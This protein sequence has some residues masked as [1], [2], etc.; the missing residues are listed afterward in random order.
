MHLNK[1]ILH[2]ERNYDVND[3]TQIPGP[4]SIKMVR[5]IVTKPPNLFDYFIHKNP[6]QFVPLY[7]KMTCDMNK[8][9]NDLKNEMI[10]NPE[11]NKSIKYFN[12]PE[13]TSPLF[14]KQTLLKKKMKSI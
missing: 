12:T 11:E 9:L 14:C 3:I 10:K 5:Y 8:K 4:Y 13:I 6:T 2:E 7:Y 1:L